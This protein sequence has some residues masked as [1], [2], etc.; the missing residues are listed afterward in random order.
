MHL[1]WCG[2]KACRISIVCPLFSNNLA[3]LGT[4]NCVY[5]QCHNPCLL[6]FFV[7]LSWPIVCLIVLILCFLCLRVADLGPGL[8]PKPKHDSNTPYI[9][10]I[11]TGFLIRPYCFL[12]SCCRMFSSRGSLRSRSTGLCILHR[13]NYRDNSRYELDP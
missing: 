11:Q 6:C 1:R 5:A 8:D 10:R 9:V 2:C 3:S 12:Q 4:G 13:A 7:A